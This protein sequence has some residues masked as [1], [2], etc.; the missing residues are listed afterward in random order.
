MMKQYIGRKGLQEAI[1]QS[2]HGKY[3]AQELSTPDNSSD[4]ATI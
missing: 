1:Q 4:Y 2:T 3:E